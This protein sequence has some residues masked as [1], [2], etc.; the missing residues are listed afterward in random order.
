MSSKDL[1]GLEAIPYFVEEGIVSLKV[2]G[3]MKGPLY[4]ATTTRVYREALDFY[5]AHHSWEN[6][7]WEKW[8]TELRKLPH[9]DATSASLLGEAGAES[10]YDERDNTDPQWGMAGTILSAC[11]DKGII[12]ACRQGFDANHELELVPFHGEALKVPI[13]EMMSPD[14]TPL[15][16]SRPSSLLRFPFQVGMVP[17]QVLRV[18]RSLENPCVP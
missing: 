9:R 10:I 7:P 17:E 3:R 13:S 15:E 11:P 14:F 4:A 8:A 6:A 5:Q 12:V 16:R 1:E 18:R 2:E